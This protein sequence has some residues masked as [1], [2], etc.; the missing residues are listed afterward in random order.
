MLSAIIVIGACVIVLAA[1]CGLIALG[2][3]FMNRTKLLFKAL[4]ECGFT[5]GAAQTGFHAIVADARTRP[6][7]YLL[8]FT[9]FGAFVLFAE[10]IMLGLV[11]LGT[12]VTLLS[13]IGRWRGFGIEQRIETGCPQAAGRIA[14]ER[15]ALWT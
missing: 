2:L 5:I 4:W 1:A 12:L 3:L 10:Y 11:A 9:V 15:S 6:G 14:G 7:S 13:A 8:G